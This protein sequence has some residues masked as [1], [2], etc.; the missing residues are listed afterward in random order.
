[1]K[2]IY[3]SVLFLLALAS[4]TLAQS[5]KPLLMRKPTVNKTHIVFSF[6]GDLWI[7]G[8]EGGEAARLTTGTGT[9]TDPVFSPDGTMIAF[10]GE[11]D[12]NIDVYVVPAEGGVPKRLTYHPGGDIVLGWTRDGK[13]V[14]F[15]SGRT[16]NLPTA[17]FFTIP[18]DGFF[19]SEIPLPMGQEAS[20]S[21]DGSRLAY[22]PFAP[23]FTQWKKYR[24]GRTTK[25]W[26]AN[27]ADSSVEEIPR[28]NTNDFNPMW[29]ENKIY[30]L[31]DR[32]YPVT[33]FSYDP[34]SRRVTQAIANN[35]LDI[36]SATV[37]PDAIVYEQFGSINLY[38]LKTGKTG[39]VNI[40]ISA[41]L[42]GVRPRYERVAN[43]ISN[44]AL[45]P[46]GARAV[47]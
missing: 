5:G 38:D 18:V 30:F 46:T 39:N 9:E 10:T 15:R 7:V 17:K 36:K 14:L 42:P 33:L 1:M 12:G 32:T 35:G 23:A 27:L 34:A 44:V 22:Q 26:L 2:K 37:G 8:R 3:L 20:F 40:S 24:G 21:P 11:Y 25:I 4:L 43:R 31:S 19:P 45:S 47:F 6:A 28:Q 29:V 13:Q 41:D 16:S